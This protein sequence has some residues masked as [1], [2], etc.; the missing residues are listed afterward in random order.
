[1][2]L[3]LALVFATLLVAPVWAQEGSETPDTAMIQPAGE[4]DLSDFLWTKRPVVV[5]A[6][7][8]AD[9]RYAEQIERLSEG[10]GML[11][12]RDVVVLTDTDPAAA[13]PLRQKLRPR[14]FM[15]VLVGKDG[16]VKLRKPLPWTVREITRS[17]DKTPE[18][19]R[20]VDQKRGL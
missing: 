12:D 4:S 6:D 1:M 13:S 19:Q 16:G 2:K 10:M 15:L 20:E 17:I 5:F 14:G 8:P 3:S 11:I 9:P 18:R 7:S